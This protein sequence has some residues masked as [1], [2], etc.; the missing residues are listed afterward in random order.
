MEPTISTRQTPS[1]SNSSPPQNR[2]YKRETAWVLLLLWVGVVVF[3]MITLDTTVLS[4]VTPAVFLFAG[5]AFSMDWA[6]KQTGLTDG[7]RDV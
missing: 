1:P 4:I 7:K 6:S 2:T 5:A 3:S